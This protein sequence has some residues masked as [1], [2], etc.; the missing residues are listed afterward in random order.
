MSDNLLNQLLV[1]HSN[2]KNCDSVWS[3]LSA[4]HCFG[5]CYLGTSGSSSDEF[6]NLLDATPEDVLANL[7]Q[8]IRYMTNVKI[9][10]TVFL[11]PD[12][13]CKDSYKNAIKSIATIVNLKDVETINTQ[14][15]KDTNG[16]ISNLLDPNSIDSNTVVIFLNVIYLKVIWK[17]KFERN[18]TRQRSFNF[19]ESYVQMMSM[20]KELCYFENSELQMIELEFKE[21]Q[22][23]MGII[24]PRVSC[25]MVNIT[26]ELIEEFAKKATFKKVALNLP[27]FKITQETDLK[28]MLHTSGVTPNFLEN[29]EMQNF[30]CNREMATVDKIS[31][32][33]VIEFNEDGVE[34]AAATYISMSRCCAIRHIHIQFL[35]DRPFS[36]YIRASHSNEVVFAGQFWNRSQPDV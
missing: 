31:Q 19:G 30:F 20:E 33:A 36:Y 2:A 12:V 25:D 5:L 16:L 6:S 32:K 23:M 27:K 29:A 4:K 1:K 3:Y 9:I 14:V 28:D 13:Q 21:P 22:L 24:L 34:A 18:L 11:K 7:Q 26:N 35:C 15:Q 8:D 17:Y 10:N